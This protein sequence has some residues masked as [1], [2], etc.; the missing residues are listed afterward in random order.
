MTNVSPVISDSVRTALADTWQRPQY[1]C[2]AVNEIALPNKPGG[3][4]LNPSRIKRIEA[5]KSRGT[6]LTRQVVQEALDDLVA[7]KIAERRAAPK[8]G[9]LEYKLMTPKQT[10]PSLDM[11]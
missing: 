6:V 3:A 9:W 10:L 1:I 11:I 4:P 7:Q 5:N 2:Y 8:G